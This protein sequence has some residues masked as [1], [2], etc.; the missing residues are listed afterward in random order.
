MIIEL[1]NARSSID[2]LME[3]LDGFIDENKLA[4]KAG[5]QLRLCLDELL[6]NV[7]SYG[8]DDGAEGR[9]SVELETDD[10]DVRVVMRDDGKPFNPFE[11]TAAPDLDA[12]VGDRDI[13]GL[14][15]FFVTSTA[16]EYSYERENDQNIVRLALNNE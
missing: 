10:K 3:G 7:I 11:E 12:D 9:I 6:T 8:F 14:G 15:V 4:D 1:T 2:R 13:G 5:H 16:R